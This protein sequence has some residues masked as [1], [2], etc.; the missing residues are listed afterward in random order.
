MAAKFAG[1]QSSLATS[2]AM[3]S[4]PITKISRSLSA[5]STMDWISQMNRFR[6]GGTGSLTAASA[7]SASLPGLTGNPSLR[8]GMASLV[9]PAGDMVMG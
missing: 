8:A 4:Q 5:S 1:S 6:D 2:R 9:K 3:R 7:L